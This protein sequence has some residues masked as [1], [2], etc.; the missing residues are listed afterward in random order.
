LVRLTTAIATAYDL[1]FAPVY[2]CATWL[3]WLLPLT[4]VLVS[5]WPRRP[6]PTGAAALAT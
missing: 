2:A 6:R 4:I 3:G 5:T 1:P